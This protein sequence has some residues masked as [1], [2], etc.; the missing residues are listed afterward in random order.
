MVNRQKSD[1][2]KVNRVKSP[3]V[4]NSTVS[5]DRQLKAFGFQY[6]L[7]ADDTQIYL[8]SPDLSPSVLGRV[9]ECLSAISSWMT[10]RHL[11]LNISKTELI[12]FPPANSSFQPDISITVENS[13]ITPTPQARC[14][15]VI[16]DSEL[17]FVTHIQSVSRSCYIHLRNISKIRPYLT[18]D[19]AK[20]LIHALIIS[21]IDYCNSLL[22]GLP[23]H[24]LSPLQ[25]ILNAAARLIFLA[26]R[27]SS[28]DPLCQS[29]HWLPVF[30]RIKYKIL[31]LTYKVHK[32]KEH[33]P[34]RPIIAGLDSLMA[35]LPHYIDLKLQHY[36]KSLK[37]YLKDSSSLL[38]IL[39]D[40]NCSPAK[41][42]LTI[43]VEAL[44]SSIPHEN[45]LE[46]VQKTLGKDPAKTEIEIKFIVDSIRFILQHNYFEFNDTYFIQQQG[47]AMGMKYREEI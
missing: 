33:P 32:N 31:L 11:K 7:Y 34:G 21:R 45:G 3:I 17:S 35:N 24:R 4:N 1:R 14:L 15:G 30:Y 22:T 29:L 18:Q 42:W 38:R 44:Y 26:R 36:V 10:S 41:Q 47:T 5:K 20:T 23:K 40:I 16:L 19:T 28:A 43:D 8:S 27:S 6:H 12:I 2:E 37:S 13:A 39:K 46:A 25:S 9:T